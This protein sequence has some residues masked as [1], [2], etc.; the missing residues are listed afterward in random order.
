MNIIFIRHGQGYHNLIKDEKTQFH[1]LYP[2]LT[3]Q[4]I[5]ECKKTYN[6]LKYLYFDLVITSPLIRAL[7]T[8]N[9]CFNNNY[10][11]AISVDLFREIVENKC[12]FRKHI[13]IIQ[14]K[15]NYVQFRGFDIN[16]TEYNQI[17]TKKNIEKRLSQI[18]L[19]LQ[20]LKSLG[21]KNIA[22][23]THGALLYNL[24]KKYNKTLHIK[25]TSFFK[26]AEWRKCMI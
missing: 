18:I 23:I 25:N 26:N 13:E 2:Q 16:E 9:I 17:E 7:Q 21:Y 10:S 22:I 8:F 15:Y 1:L 19:F 3:K 20:H 6:D 14:K 24:F 4:G 11:K 5:F 12:D